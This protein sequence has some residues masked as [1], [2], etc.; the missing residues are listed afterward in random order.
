MSTKKIGKRE[1]LKDSKTRDFTSKL[2]DYF[3][4]LVEIP[5]IRVGKRQTI[6]TLIN[7]EAWLF[8]QFLREESSVWKPRM[9]IPRSIFRK[10]LPSNPELKQ[11]TQESLC[12]SSEQVRQRSFGLED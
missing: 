10:H 11:A 7:D 6:E 9:S 12:R 1:Y 4:I 2:N 8:G 5:R 3:E